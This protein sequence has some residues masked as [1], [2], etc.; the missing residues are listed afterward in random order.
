MRPNTPVV[1]RFHCDILEDII[2]AKKRSVSK[3]SDKTVLHM[4]SIEEMQKILDDIAAEFPQEF[5]EELNGG[6][7]LLPDAKLHD[8]DLHNDLFILGQYFRGG[9]MG[10]YIAVYYG[11]FRRVFGHLPLEKLKSEL[12]S[13]VRHEFR[14]HLE[15]L[16]GSDDLELI[17]EDNLARYREER[18]TE[19]RPAADDFESDSGGYDDSESEEENN[20]RGGDNDA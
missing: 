8:K 5:F 7:I 20:N 1:F 6:I 15:S 11:S 17:D 4:I 2:Q 19:D 16:A 13:T 3:N 14:H 10:R 18:R 12:R 9:S